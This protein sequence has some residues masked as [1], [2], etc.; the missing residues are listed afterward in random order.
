MTWNV[1]GCRDVEQRG[2]NENFVAGVGL[3]DATLWARK[4]LDTCGPCI[5]QLIAPQ[6]VW[7]KTLGWPA[8]PKDT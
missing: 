3:N 2:S 8:V 4:D 1:V 6:C 5:N 7:T